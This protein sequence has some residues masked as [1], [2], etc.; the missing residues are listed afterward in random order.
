MAMK[1]T[2]S[3]RS[4]TGNCPLYTVEQ[5]E[6]FEKVF[7]DCQKPSRS[8]RLEMICEHPVLSNIESQQ[9]KLWF[10]DRRCG[11][12]E[13]KAAIE[14]QTVNEKLA[15]TKKLL[16]LEN[17]RLQKE[18]L[19]LE[20]EKEYILQLLE[21]FQ[22]FPTRTYYYGYSKIIIVIS[23]FSVIPSAL[24]VQIRGW[25]SFFYGTLRRLIA[26]VSAAT[27][28]SSCE[29][30]VNSPENPFR[31]SDDCT[32][33]LLLADKTTRDFLSKA[34]EGFVDWVPI[35]R[36]KALHYTGLATDGSDELIHTPSNEPAILP[37][38][39]Q[40]LSRGLSNTADDGGSLIN[41]NAAED[42]QIWIVTTK[43][44]G[45]MAKNNNALSMSGKILCV[46][47]SM[48]LKLCAGVDENA[49]CSAFIFF[50]IKDTQAEDS[51][52]PPFTLNAEIP[53][54][55]SYTHVGL[56]LS[57]TCSVAVKSIRSNVDSE[58]LRSDFE[59]LYSVLKKLWHHL[60]AMQFCSFKSLPVCFLAN[61]MELEILDIAL[62]SLQDME[63]DQILG[64]HAQEH[65]TS[66][67][68]RDLLCS[69]A[70]DMDL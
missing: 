29:T 18:L 22:S 54:S 61:Q 45:S 51:M 65:L 32:G 27:T 17:D 70:I 42:L 60:D 50:P 69:G 67:S 63:L 6:V 19:Q 49:L 38:F 3:A 47:A 68:T 28:D 41:Y 4:S 2:S 11:D 16:L 46:K 58:V 25:F 34:I 36:M 21:N 59:S 40:K 31:T 9:I 30:T 56:K 64:D 35:P 14:L 24:S 1:G 13:R 37:F 53:P 33:F 7:G 52:L 57:P 44:L 8:Q 26:L 62:V 23:S 5:V 48:P 20:N 12:K 43:N 66:I 39:S 10:R 15:T 55:G